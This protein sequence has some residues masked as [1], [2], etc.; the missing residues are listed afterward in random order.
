MK[1]KAKVSHYLLTHLAIILFILSIIAIIVLCLVE[2][3]TSFLD[4]TKQLSS[5]LVIL[6]VS[7]FE[8]LLFAFVINE[9]IKKNRKITKQSLNL[10]RKGITKVIKNG[11]IPSYELEHFF[12]DALEIK[13]MVVCGKTFLLNNEKAFISALKRGCKIKM[14]IANEN[15]DFIKEITEQL[16]QVGY[17]EN[18]KQNEQSEEIT[19]V[20][21]KLNKLGKYGDIKYATFDTEYR[22]PFYLGYFNEDDDI[23]IKG[24]FN[25]ILP[26]ASP[27]DYLMFGGEI[28]RSDKEDYIYNNARTNNH[29]M[30]VDLELHFDY[31]WGKYYRN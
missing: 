18:D 24:Y 26:V 17:K 9:E 4:N 11:K 12:N 23:T 10:E 19:F 16:N 28:K 27:R 29:N 20:K 3:F 6:S 21:D 14:L 25:M 8:S 7:I 15:S 2:A 5:E 30:I 31:L 22:V 1:L 13:I